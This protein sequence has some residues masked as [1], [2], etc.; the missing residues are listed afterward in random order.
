MKIINIQHCRTML[1]CGNFVIDEYFGGFY[2]YYC[3]KHCCDDCLICKSI[4]KIY[5]NL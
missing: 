4:P 2:R 1:K 3:I 5:L